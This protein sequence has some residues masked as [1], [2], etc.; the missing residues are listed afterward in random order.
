MDHGKRRETP[1]TARWIVA[2][3]WTALALTSAT[4]QIETGAFSLPSPEPVE[5]RHIRGPGVPP[6][7]LFPDSPEW[8]GAAASRI[9]LPPRSQ[10]NNIAD[11]QPTNVVTD[12]GLVSR[13]GHDACAQLLLTSALR[14]E[15]ELS[16]AMGYLSKRID[17][18]PDI[19]GPVVD[20]PGEASS[21]VVFVDNNMKPDVV[22]HFAFC[23]WTADAG[24]SGFI[25]FNGLHLA[26]DPAYDVGATAMHELVHAV[27]ATTIRSSMN[28][29][30]P[31]FDNILTEDDKWLYEGSAQFA[32][33]RFIAARGTAPETIEPGDRKQVFGAA[34]YAI[35]LFH[36]SNA[37]K[38]GSFFAHLAERYGNGS[39]SLL[40]TIFPSDPFRPVAREA[41]AVR[42]FDSL[43]RQRLNTAPFGPAL[44]L[45]M[46]DIASYPGTSFEGFPRTPP[47]ITRSEWLGTMF[48]CKGVELSKNNLRYDRP[49]APFM[50]YAGQC[51]QIAIPTGS[52]K[53]EIMIRLVADDLATAD[54]FHLGLAAITAGEDAYQVPVFSCA[55]ALDASLEEGRRAC[56]PIREGPTRDGATHAVRWVIPVPLLDR[57][58][59]IQVVYNQ[60]PMRRFGEGDRATRRFVTEKTPW[61]EADLAI[62]LKLTDT[63]GATGPAPSGSGVHSAVVI[64]PTT[65]AFGPNDFNPFDF[66]DDERS[67]LVGPENRPILND[68]S[69]VA[70]SAIQMLL[71]TAADPV[72]MAKLP[73]LASRRVDWGGAR[74][75]VR[76]GLAGD[77]TVS[78][79][80]LAFMRYTIR[81]GQL[82]VPMT[83]TQRVRL[84]LTV[85]R[86]DGLFHARLARWPEMTKGTSYELARTDMV[87]GLGNQVEPEVYATVQVTARAEN[88]VTLRFA[89]ALGPLAGS[90]VTQTFPFL[91]HRVRR[92]DRD[93][94][95]TALGD[96]YLARWRKEVRQIMR[97]VDSAEPEPEG[98]GATPAPSPQQPSESAAASPVCPCTCAAFGRHVAASTPK[99]PAQSFLACADA[100]CSI[101]MMCQTPDEPVAQTLQDMCRW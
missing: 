10:W 61:R 74:R 94:V 79:F 78:G 54:G 93:L 86:D 98:K 46:A 76:E 99:H 83:Q 55:D 31:C 6:I 17:V 69:R 84:A 87:G 100:C 2:A 7:N 11:W 48:N 37:Y 81:D 89:F 47:D 1:M 70:V 33:A 49:A 39:V 34:N 58:Q 8:A 23:D 88:S 101:Y 26:V 90:S 20:G 92:P 38:G 73:R 25:A 64:E 43:M 15:A 30:R 59:Q 35:G 71:M 96:F 28:A 45:A 4:A 41:D 85:P 80:D 3:L 36:P 22:A 62:A 97:G 67:D 21:L 9:G 63:A 50:N 53:A 82:S 16:A 95:G 29:R 44:T 72:T 24:Q 14:L 18:S 32:A 75:E 68:M 42:W 77:D 60:S 57:P 19:L 66:G 27:Q 5:H 13:R 40:D 51:H 56:L 52:G 91:E 12:C 65:R